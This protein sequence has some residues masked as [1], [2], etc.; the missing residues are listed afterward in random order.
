[1]SP[2]GLHICISHLEPENLEGQ[3]ANTSYFFSIFKLTN[4]LLIEIYALQI[5]NHPTQIFTNQVFFFLYSGLICHHK[6]GFGPQKQEWAEQKGNT[7]QLSYY[8]F[9]IIYHMMSL[10]AKLKRKI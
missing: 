8:C 6:V 7:G 9:T 10:L 1:M 3:T 4:V 2:D 5:Q